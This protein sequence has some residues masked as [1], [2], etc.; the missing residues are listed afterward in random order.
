MDELQTPQEPQKTAPPWFAIF[1]AVLALYIVVGMSLGI[2][3]A[4]FKDMGNRIFDMTF[5]ALMTLFVS[6]AY[7]LTKK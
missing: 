6:T 2:F 4:D 7:S 5:G 3:V 1:L